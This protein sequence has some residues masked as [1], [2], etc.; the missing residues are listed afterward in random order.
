MIGLFDDGDERLVEWHPGGD[1]C[2]ELAGRER[3]HLRAKLGGFA[4][5]CRRRRLYS[6]R[7]KAVATQ[8]IAHRADVF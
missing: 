3:Q 4:S 5:P 8:L 1:Q 6:R 7:E 2:R